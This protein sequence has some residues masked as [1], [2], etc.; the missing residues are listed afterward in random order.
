MIEKKV[1]N[2]EQAKDKALRLLTFRSHSEKELKDKLRRAGAEDN[3][4]ENIIEF[5]K[6][7]K[8]INDED[9]ARRKARDLKNLKKYGKRRIRSELFSVGIDA[10]TIE[11]VIMEI[12]FDDEEDALYPLV[13]KKLGGDFE[14]KSV[15]R[16]IRYFM[17]RGYEF[18]D[19]KRCVG[20]A[21]ELS[22]DE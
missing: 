20:R 14:K 17:Y 9:F 15:D 16:C 5:C 12:D 7:Y 21:R 2:Y 18:S 19:I 8:F 4:I 13:V 3:D 11:S 10:E 1:L 6:E 22:D